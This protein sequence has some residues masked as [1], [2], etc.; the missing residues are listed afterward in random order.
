MLDV[1]TTLREAVSL[2]LAVKLSPFYSSLAN[3]ARRLERAG[4]D[5]LVIFNRF[6]QPDID[7]ENLEVVP[8]ARLSSPT[9]LLLRLRWLAILVGPGRRLARRHR[10]R[11]HRRRRRQ[12]RHGRGPRR[13]DGLGAPATRGPRRS[14]RIRAEL[15]R[16]LEEHGYESL[17]QMQGSMSAGRG[18]SPAALERVHYMRVLQSWRPEDDE[19]RR[20][21]NT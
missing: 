2:P 8:K 7:V 12:G 18:A 19:R 13:P 21:G 16:W 17:R 5:G 15:A 4:A 3:L 9:E 14:S 1:V 10:R 6:Y 11:P 20:G